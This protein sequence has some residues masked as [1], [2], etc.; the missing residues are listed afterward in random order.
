MN[1]CVNINSREFKD[2]AKVANMNPVILAAKV[3]IW[4]EENGLDKFP[5]LSQLMS[6][7]AINYVIDAAQILSSPEAD[8]VFKKADKGKWPLDKV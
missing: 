4:Q 2:L 7:N 8:I 5:T 1:H 6:E 3:S